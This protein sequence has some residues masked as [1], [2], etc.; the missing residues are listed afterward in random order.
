MDF[1]QMNDMD[2]LKE[3]ILENPNFNKFYYFVTIYPYEQSDPR[4][5]KSNV[6]RIKFGNE[7][8]DYLQRVH[9]DIYKDKVRLHCNGEGRMEHIVKLE[10]Y[11][12]YT[13]EECIILVLDKWI[14][15]YTS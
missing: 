10:P 3:I 4:N 1:S 7:N 8:A 15:H 9:I 6:E 13:N 2:N 5:Y 11:K 14:C 12:N